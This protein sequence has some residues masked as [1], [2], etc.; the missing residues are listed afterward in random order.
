MGFS[1]FVCVL[2]SASFGYSLLSSVLLP[3]RMTYGNSQITHNPRMITGTLDDDGEAYQGELLL[4][5]F[6]HYI[7]GMALTFLLIIPTQKSL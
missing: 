1:A 3:L 6:Y 4:P 2:T 5:A 7:R